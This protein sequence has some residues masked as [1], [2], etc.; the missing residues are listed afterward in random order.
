MIIGIIFLVNA[1]WTH[2]TGKK[3][4]FNGTFVE[5]AGSGINLLMWCFGIGFINF[6]EF[7]DGDGGITNAN[8]Y[9]FTWGAFFAAL[10]TFCDVT[11]HV[12]RPSEAKHPRLR[13]WG[14]M[15]TGNIIVMVSCIKSHKSYGC[16]SLESHSTYCAR[17]LYG[18][19]LGC[20]SFFFGLM[21]MLAIVFGY[22]IL[23]I[24][25]LLSFMIAVCWGIAVWAI[26]STLGPGASI[27]N[28]YY[29]T[30][31]SFFAS[32]LIF[33]NCVAHF[34]PAKS[35][36]KA[37]GSGKATGDGKK[38]KDV[39]TAKAVDKAEDNDV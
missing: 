8:V 34:K 14:I 9:Y 15:A 19:C 13:T 33:L 28:L 3:N 29:F 18:I 38:T 6:S 20:I 1:K 2:H 22:S 4:L 31:I 32:L 5:I 10:V 39:Q 27:G 24:E 7:E 35:K 37:S 16:G 25:V 36:S 21:I 12:L 30:W 11:K 17:C 23:Q 26:T